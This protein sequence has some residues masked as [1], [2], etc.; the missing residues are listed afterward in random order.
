MNMFRKFVIAALTMGGFAVV[1]G[2]YVSF[3]GEKIGFDGA[4]VTTLSGGDVLLTFTQ[5][6]TFSLPKNAKAR[7]LA[8]GG[9]GAGGAMVENASRGAAGG[10]GGG[11]VVDRN[12][13]LEPGEYTVEVGRGGQRVQTIVQSWTGDDGESSTVSFDGEYIVGAKGGGG[14]GSVKMNG[15]GTDGGCGG[16]GSWYSEFLR[17]GNGTDGQGCAGGMPDNE[18]RGGGGGGASLNSAEGRGKANGAGGAGRVCDITGGNVTYA[19]GGRGGDREDESYDPK[20]GAG[21]G[22]GGDGAVD[23]EGGAGADGVV[24]VRISKLFDYTLVDYPAAVAN[25]DWVNGKTITAFSLATCPYRAAIA[26]VE[27]ETSV[28]CTSEGSGDDEKHIGIGQHAFILYLNEEYRWK[29]TDADGKVQ[30]SSDPVVCYWRVTDPG[31]VQVATIDVAKNVTWTSGDRAVITL[32][33]HATPEKKQTV[34]NV[35]FLGSLCGAHGFSSSVFNAAVNAITEVGNVDYYFFK[36]NDSRTFSPALSGSYKKGQK[37]SGT[38]NIDRTSLENTTGQHG[39]LYEFYDQIAKLKAEIDAG[40]RPEYDYIVFSFDRGLIGTKFIDTHARESEVVNY[41]K[42]FYARNAV[43]WLVDKEAG[44]DEKLPGGI[45]QTPWSPAPICYA[46]GSSYN[47]WTTLDYYAKN[48]GSSNQKNAGSAWGYKAYKAMVGMFCPTKYPEINQ[49][50]YGSSADQKISSTSGATVLNRVKDLTCPGIDAKYQCIYDN[51]AKVAATLSTVIVAQPMF[52]QMIDKIAVSAGGLEL[53]NVTAEWGTNDWT[54]VCTE[55]E[56]SFGKDGNIIVKV[57]QVRDE[58]WLI[59]NAMVKDNGNFRS[60]V[61]ATYNERTGLWEKDPNDGAVRAAMVAENGETVFVE[62]KAKTAVKWSFA[63]KKIT[64]GV[65]HGEGEFVINGFITNECSVAEG[66]SP[67]V[68][69]R[70]KAGYVLDYLEVDGVQQKFG[71]D[72][73]NWIFDEIA[74]DHDIQVGFKNALDLSSLPVASP[75]TAEY[76]GKAHG[77]K[78]SDPVFEDGWDFEWAPLYSLTGEDGSFSPDVGLVNAGTAKVYVRYGIKNQLGYDSGEYA[79]LTAWTGV[80]EVTVNRRDL[81]VTF[82]DYVQAGSA[83]GVKTSGFAY[84]ITGGE[85]VTGDRLDVN[86]GKCGNRPT[87]AGGPCGTIVANGAMHVTTPGFDGCNYNISVVPGRYYY[88]A[89][90]VVASATGVTK[91]YDG[92]ASSITVTP[93]YPFDM[94][95][96]DL[97]TSGP[98]TEKTELDVYDK[99]A[100]SSYDTYYFDNSQTPTKNNYGTAYGTKSYTSK[101]FGGKTYYNVV[102]NATLKTSIGGSTEVTTWYSLTGND[103]D[104]SAELP[105]ISDVGE[106]TVF[107]KVCYASNIVTRTSGTYEVKGY[108][109]KTDVELKKGVLGFG[110]QTVTVFFKP[111]TIKSGAIPETVTTN[112][113]EYTPAIG[114]AKIVITPRNLVITA[115]SAEKAKYD[116][117]PLT[118][119]GY[120]VSGDEI[121]GGDIDLSGL[122]M[123]AESTITLPGTVA[124]VIDRNSVKYGANYNAKNYVVSFVDGAL[125]VGRNQLVTSADEVGKLYDGKPT[126]PVNIVIRDSNGNPI[127]AGGYTIRYAANPWDEFTTDVPVPPTNAGEYSFW[128]VVDGGAGYGV[129]TNHTSIVVTNRTLTITAKSASKLYDGEPLVCGEYELEGEFVV[130]EGIE[131][132]KMTSDS[133]RTSPG[134]AK[135]RIGEIVWKDGTNPQNYKVVKVDGTLTVTRQLVFEVEDDGE[136]SWTMNPGDGEGPGSA[137]VIV[138]GKTNTVVKLDNGRYAIHVSEPCSDAEYEFPPEM[139]VVEKH[140]VEFVFTEDDGEMFPD[141]VVWYPQAEPDE[142]IDAVISLDPPVSSVEEFKQR[143]EIYNDPYS[144]WLPVYEKDEDGN[145]VVV[146]IRTSDG[147]ECVTNGEEVAVLESR[148]QLAVHGTG[149]ITFGRIEVPVRNDDGTQG[150]A[151]PDFGSLTVVIDGDAYTIPPLVDLDEGCTVVTNDGVIVIENLKLKVCGYSDEAGVAVSAGDTHYVTM[152]FTRTAGDP[153]ANTSAVVSGITW[154]TY[155]ESDDGGTSW[156]QDKEVWIVDHEDAEDEGYVY[157]C[158]RPELK[159][160]EELVEWVTRSSENDKIK[161]KFGDTREALAACKPVTAKLSE[162]HEIL[163]IRIWVKVPVADVVKTSAYWKIYIE[164]SKPTEVS[165]KTGPVSDGDAAESA[166]T[167]GILQIDSGLKNTMIAIPWTDYSKSDDTAAAIPVAKLVKPEG[168]EDGDMIYSYVKDGVYSVWMLDRG[169]WIPQPTYTVDSKGK[170]ALKAAPRN[171][172]E[173]RVNRGSALWVVRQNPKDAQGKS[174]PIFV[175]GQTSDKGAVSEIAGGTDTKSEPTMLGSPFTEPIDVND[176]AWGENPSSKDVITIPS[177]GTPI[178]LTWKKGKWGYTTATKDSRGRLVTQRTEGYLLMPGKAFWYSRY[179]A[180]F[181]VQWSVKAK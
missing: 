105:R 83:Y 124:N 164:G 158:F 93:M 13:I 177:E 4:A 157:L 113:I 61:N 127:P 153:S 100:S 169:E 53:E 173:A 81:E 17:G 152:Y 155:A 134:K 33:V 14:G 36:A 78:V 138:D 50:M 109:D 97:P 23:G 141:D 94:K 160:E 178:K 26:A 144:G 18:N 131:S 45:V 12:Q 30:T 75:V 110:R 90:D 72:T 120:T 104:W 133:V 168:L 67:E 154:M 101:T 149:E 142:L 35:L 170:Q 150:E 16:G 181:E 9:G 79:E 95:D 29:W 40:T 8:V 91:E 129:M 46:S 37:R 47:Y 49:K 136:F 156:I 130:G 86:A 41:L 112:R 128:Y 65:V 52:L 143:A 10:G 38:V 180:G 32:E 99:T 166:N 126:D 140:T 167:F 145:P 172:E 106:Y 70:G 108:G 15:R 39:T 159:V 147:S 34:P 55:D 165:G 146:G 115:K 56:I 148:F 69:F 31:T 92:K 171:R 132:V 85:L 175:Y 123:T 63:A 20:D 54:H 179:G 51:A 103:D 24:M 19:R 176:I 84:R 7:I 66:Y 162:K 125:T 118:E 73:Y 74:A 80:A 48:W 28:V 163:P 88:P 6:G 11:G 122:A 3:G 25:Q 137:I 44:A 87:V 161:V 119:S 59:V 98:V 64:G 151:N 27:G 114:S 77:C 58:A 139:S 117:Q 89:N 116:G 121:V 71:H 2:G 68:V 96:A 22:C 5:G 111:T 57:G 174:K 135:N 102:S 76:D 43:V 60:S 1:Y 42:G 107:Y 82:D 21:Y 62:S